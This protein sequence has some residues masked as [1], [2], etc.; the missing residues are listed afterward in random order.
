VS[1]LVLELKHPLRNPVHLDM[2]SPD[3]LAGK[4][5]TEVASLEVW[6]GNR[7][8]KLKSLFN[9]QGEP[10]ATPQEMT[11]EI[12]G[13]LSKTRRIG[14]NMTSGKI[15]IKGTGGLYIGESMKGG[16]I[17]ID[18]NAGSWLG[19]NMKSGTIEVTGNAGDFVGAASRGSK[20][21]MAGGS[22]VIKGNAGSEVGSF[23]HSG[24]I[25]ISSSTEMFAGVHMHGGTVHIG[26]DCSGRAGAHMVGGKIIISGKLPSPL[27]SFSFEEI[28]DQTKIEKD[29]IRG[30]FYVFSGD[31]NEDGTG[32]LFVDVGHNP[33]LK[34]YEKFLET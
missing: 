11:L 22:I 33:Q 3:S 23:M 20:K 28:R 26:G 7:K 17:L 19:S 2:L 5:A 9:I 31:N 13:D 15:H 4:K 6:E 34:W 12:I 14:Y 24:T 25:R 16:T 1:G 29:S 8:V 18:G 32:R 30:P 10:Q 27:P 21:G